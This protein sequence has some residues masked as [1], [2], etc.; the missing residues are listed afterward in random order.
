MAAAPQGTNIGRVTI[1][2]NLSDGSSQEGT[3]D[4]SGC[5]FLPLP[6]GTYHVKWGKE[7][8][9]PVERDLT[10]GE[11]VT[12]YLPPIPLLPI[13]NHGDSAGD[14]SVVVVNA[15]L[16]ADAT[17]DGRHQPFG[18]TFTAGLLTDPRR[19]ISTGVH[20]YVFLGIGS[21]G[22]YWASPYLALSRSA[23]ADECPITSF[24]LRPKAGP[25][26][27]VIDNDY[28][29]VTERDPDTGESYYEARSR[30]FRESEIVVYI[31]QRDQI[32]ATLTPP[33]APEGYYYRWTVC[34]ITPSTATISPI[35]KLGL[36]PDAPDDRGG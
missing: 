6:P 1:Q 19:S 33:Q 7:G 11:G 28:E 15:S 34:Q 20:S 12:T 23:T 5:F 18:A 27:L 29:Q 3:T 9:I 8:Y 16:Q 25:R 36:S 4:A 24:V 21:A 30:P 13:R 22:N 2:T 10:V 32:L 14:I 17:S 26:T 35:N 31:A